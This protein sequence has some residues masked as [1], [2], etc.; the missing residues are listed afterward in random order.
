M[1]EK[2]N[3]DMID[4]EADSILTDEAKMLV[5]VEA[6]EI[7]AAIESLNV[8][9]EQDYKVACGLGQR[10]KDVLKRLESFRKA[11]V[12]PMND[13]VSNVN[14]I[15]KRLS[16]RFAENQ[17]KIDKAVAGYFESRKKTEDIRTVRSQDTGMR[18]SMQ[19]RWVFEIV[20]AGAVPREYCCPDEAKIGKAVRAGVLKELQGV[21]IFE[22]LIPVYANE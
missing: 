13:A 19:R 4:Q 3:D 18:T 16:V 17:S 10:N 5:R 11:I 20:D 21:K 1:S 7:G 22:K 14:N 6:R 9:N 8:R 12:G 15:F 2:N